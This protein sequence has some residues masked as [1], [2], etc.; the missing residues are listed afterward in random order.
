MQRDDRRSEEDAGE[1][2]KEA[3]TAAPNVVPFARRPQ[4]RPAPP[5]T[6]DDDDPG[7]TAA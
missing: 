4:P 6:P 3:E 2:R 7:P 1:A 5:D